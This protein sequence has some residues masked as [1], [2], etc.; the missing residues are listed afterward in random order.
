[1]I[2]K[3]MDVERRGLTGIFYIVSRLDILA[4][5]KQGGTDLLGGPIDPEATKLARRVLLRIRN[6]YIRGKF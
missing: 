4:H 2:P 5:P 3:P 6:L 1:M